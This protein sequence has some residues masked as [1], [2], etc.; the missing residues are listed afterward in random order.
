MHPMGCF[1]VG[2]SFWADGRG[3]SGYACALLTCA[4]A[5]VAQ[6]RQWGAQAQ[7]KTELKQ[8]LQN[9]LCESLKKKKWEFWIC[10]AF[11]HR[12]SL[13]YVLS[14]FASFCSTACCS[15]ILLSW[16]LKVTVVTSSCCWTGSVDFWV[17]E[18]SAH[19][20]SIVSVPVV[21]HCLVCLELFLAM[22]CE[23]EMLIDKV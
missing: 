9:H 2:S 19:R 5:S 18:K 12:S 11:R 1:N 23:L 3:A 22:F 10:V 14:D 8:L 13:P 6:W 20:C 16:S 15:W 21:L 17:V 7:T 4:C